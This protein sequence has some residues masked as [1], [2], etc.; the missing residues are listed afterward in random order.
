M[1]RNFQHAEPG[2]TSSFAIEPPANFKSY[3]LDTSGKPN[4]RTKDRINF[5]IESIKDLTLTAS[6]IR[7][8]AGAVFGLWRA[9]DEEIW[10]GPQSAAKFWGFSLKTGKRAIMGVRKRRL[11]ILQEKGGGRS[12][13]NKYS[14]GGSF[15]T[16]KERPPFCK[17][18]D[19]PVQKQGQR[20][21]PHTE[22]KTISAHTTV[23]YFPFDERKWIEH[24]KETYPDWDEKD[25]R[26]SFLSAL[27]KGEGLRNWKAFAAKCYQNRRKLPQSP[28][29]SVPTSPTGHV[30]P[31]G[32]FT[33]D[34]ISSI[35]N[36]AT[37]GCTQ[38]AK[39]SF[40]Q[41]RLEAERLGIP[42]FRPIFDSLQRRKWMTKGGSPV[43]NW[44]AYL[45]RVSLSQRYD[46][47][48]L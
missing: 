40:D 43:K 29:V 9:D 1:N 10:I 13:S 44:K 38:F 31:N 34:H 16:D 4:F 12:N 3:P 17:N 21:P 37:G 8:V 48:Y 20:R 42:N 14:L 19:I 7:V 41:F 35:L 46:E 26:G 23:R 36:W 25:I 30:P 27:A 2:T 11:F 15:V 32:Q 22:T 18:G 24:C 39:P 33:Q 47:F 5:F 28:P 6:E 45:N